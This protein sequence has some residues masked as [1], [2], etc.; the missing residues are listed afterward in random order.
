MVRMRVSAEHILQILPD[1]IFGETRKRHQLMQ[2]RSYSHAREI[3][4]IHSCVTRKSSSEFEA[5]WP[6]RSE[7]SAAGRR[8]NSSTHKKKRS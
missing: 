2:N 8:G 6:F 1:L 5:L 7:S 3:G 4:I